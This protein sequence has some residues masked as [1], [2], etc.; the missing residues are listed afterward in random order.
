VLPFAY[1]TLRD[2]LGI[3]AFFDDDFVFP[4]IWVRDFG[5]FI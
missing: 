5:F 3:V 4:E 2:G 1:D